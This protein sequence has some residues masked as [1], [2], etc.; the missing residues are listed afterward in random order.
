VSQALARALESDE[1]EDIPQEP[2]QADMDEYIEA[3]SQRFG[4]TEDYQ[5]PFS[6][7]IARQIADYERRRGV[8]PIQMPTMTEEFGPHAATY[9]QDINVWNTRRRR[10][11][12]ER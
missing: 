8:Q 10:E 7:Q 4:A 12:S 3:Q 1:S 2:S 11:R 6:Q 9:T 5:P